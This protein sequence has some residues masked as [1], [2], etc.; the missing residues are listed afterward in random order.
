M[1]RNDNRREYAP[2]R[3]APGIS[4]RSPSRRPLQ[5][6]VLGHQLSMATERYLREQD[7]NFRIYKVILHIETFD[8][9]F[10]AAE[11]VF[12]ELAN[13]GCDL[14][15]RTPTVFQAAGATVG[16]LA[17]AAAWHGLTGS[18]PNILNLIRIGD[19]AY[20]PSPEL[21]VLELHR[22]S[23][24]IRQDAE[25]YGVRVLV[26][27]PETVESVDDGYT[28]DGVVSL[29]S[30]R[31][32]I[33]PLRMELD[34]IQEEVSRKAR[35]EARQERQEEVRTTPRSQP[36][37]QASKAPSRSTETVKALDEKV[38]TVQETSMRA[39][40][41]AAGLIKVQHDSTTQ[42]VNG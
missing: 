28:C 31:N 40:M 22:F 39:A 18:F 21:P 7:P 9:V 36:T 16:S 13:Q 14:S 42:A 34:R 10:L 20:G 32:R 25:R 5:V 29:Q 24:Q 1:N 17:L 33:R 12:K 27:T 30:G 38:R 6:I 26:E 3:Y 11:E 41:I 8:Q 4:H 23:E 19:W 15:G 2:E 35:L 37:S